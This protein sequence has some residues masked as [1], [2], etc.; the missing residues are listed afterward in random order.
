MRILKNVR[1]CVS[2]LGK[3][4]PV[5]IKEK[6]SGPKL[7]LSKSFGKMKYSRRFLRQGYL[8]NSCKPRLEPHPQT[9]TPCRR[10]EAV[11]AASASRAALSEYK[12]T[13]KNWPDGKGETCFA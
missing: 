12:T 8:C 6:F 9:E 2:D 5:V 1:F 10:C 7:I 3:N 13:I 4:Y 11:C